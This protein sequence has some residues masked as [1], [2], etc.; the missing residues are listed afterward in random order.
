LKGWADPPKAMLSAL[1]VAVGLKLPVKSSQ[2]SVTKQAAPKTT[3]TR[4]GR[5]DQGHC[6]F[7]ASQSQ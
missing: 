3:T 6:C 7:S 2:L 1:I 5:Q 4:Q